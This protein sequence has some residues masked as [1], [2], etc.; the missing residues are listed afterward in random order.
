[1]GNKAY[2]KD[3]KR[4]SRKAEKLRP[5]G[6]VGRK[7]WHIKDMIKV[8]HKNE[9][10]RT[11]LCD[12]E[13]GDNLCGYGYAGTGKTYLAV[14]M[15]MRSVLDADEPQDRVIIV[16]S[17]VSTRDVGFLPGTLDEK[18]ELY[19]TPYRDIL[20]R[21]F[22]KATTYDDMKARGLVEFMPTSFIRGLTWDNAVVIVDEAQNLTMHEL[23]S[24]MT[25][26]GRNTRII[27][28]GDCGQTDFTR[29]ATGFS[30]AVNIFKSMKG[31][32]VV[33]FRADDIVRSKIVKDWILAYTKAQP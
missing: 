29:E 4:N 33:K 30:D 27:L 28:V 6:E 8:S 10:Q 24:V 17:A 31:F 15:A 11:M 14:V 23:N 1:M 2:D 5:E 3:S 9:S 32:S 25:R 20:Q 13:H 26:L 21:L 12:Y 18:T 22:K 16:R 19:E 7:S